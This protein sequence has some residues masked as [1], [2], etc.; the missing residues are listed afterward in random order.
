MD[1]STLGGYAAVHGRAPGFEGAD[2]CAYTA[3]VE[4]E[5]ADDGDDAWVGYVVFV[6]WAAE[7][8]AIMGHVET[9]DLTRARSR[10][11][12]RAAVEALPLTRVKDEL[13]AALE[14]KRA[15]EMDD[16]APLE[17]G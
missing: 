10:E 3:A 13:D 14:R 16:A 9:G 12:A 11:A 7:V 5:P 15:W 4:T 1:D 17:D 2:G 6:R 8:S